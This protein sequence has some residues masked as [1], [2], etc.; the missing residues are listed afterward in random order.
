[1][2]SRASIGSR[3][4][5]VRYGAYT[6]RRAVSTMGRMMFCVAQF[7]TAANWYDLGQTKMAKWL[8]REDLRP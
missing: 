7:E 4:R 3:P 8:R 1:M 5:T 6:A 2:P